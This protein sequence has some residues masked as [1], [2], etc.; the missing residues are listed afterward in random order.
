MRD[1]KIHSRVLYDFN[2]PLN[3]IDAA[4]LKFVN[5]LVTQLRHAYLQS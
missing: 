5:E 2:F 3:Y 1:H 4:E